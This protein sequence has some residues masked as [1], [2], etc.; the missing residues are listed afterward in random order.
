MT[1]LPLIFILIA[2]C[3]KN[4]QE[5]INASTPPNFETSPQNTNVDHL[6]DGNKGG[7]ITVTGGKLRGLMIEV[8][9]GAV[10]GSQ[11]IQVKESALLTA[12]DQQIETPTAPFTIQS[13]A[14]LTGALNISIPLPG[15]PNKASLVTLTEQASPTKN[16][17]VLMQPLTSDAL[18]VLTPISL[19]IHADAVQFDITQ[20]G[21][22]QLISASPTY[23]YQKYFDDSDGLSYLLQ[24][25]SGSPMRSRV[26]NTYHGKSIQ[27]LED[28]WEDLPPVGAIQ[29][30][31]LGPK[32]TI[33]QSTLF[34]QLS[35][36]QKQGKTV[37]LLRPEQGLG[38]NGINC[39]AGENET[40]F[41]FTYAED[42]SPL[43][44][45]EET[46]KNQGIVTEKFRYEESS[47]QLSMTT[48]VFVQCNASWVEQ[49]VETKQ[50]NRMG[51][52]TQQTIRND[53]DAATCILS[54]QDVTE[55]VIVP[56]VILLSFAPH[57][58]TKRL[59][60]I[61]PQPGSAGCQ[62][63]EVTFKWD[64]LVRLQ[65]KSTRCIVD[66]QDPSKNE[67]LEEVFYSY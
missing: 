48:T 56:E 47:N 15:S 66:E 27:R 26:I 22:I 54:P 51:Q 65:E 29:I 52:L 60:I 9:N 34:E 58:Q 46:R 20:W 24:S 25:I 18:I 63:K 57:G 45:V 7:T 33:I 67:K 40:T 10:S 49:H 3:A 1:F 11:S 61:D 42:E 32:F 6:I 59:R 4:K 19:I 8:P 53:F 37:T 38:I 5:Q 62:I 28:L 21:S 12:N 64:H 35:Q 30:G 14:Q 31:P 55:T 39:Q 16:Y 13:D 41:R 17:F 44:I 50:F 2:F 23:I 36:T 43:N